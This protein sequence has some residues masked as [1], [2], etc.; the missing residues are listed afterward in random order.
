M[1]EIMPYIW[2][3]I[4]VVLAIVELSTTQFVSLWFVIGAVVC[5]IASATFLEG[6]IFWQTV[7]FVAVSAACLLATKPLVKKLRKKNFEKTNSDKYIGKTGKV[8]SDIGYNTYTGQVEVEGKK[9]TATTSDDSVIKAGTT[10]KV[11]EI[12]GVKFIV[13]PVN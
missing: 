13:T 6:Y 4:A 1:A 10:V 7:L 3:G 11:L 8:I 5:A 9:W 2:I 12:Q